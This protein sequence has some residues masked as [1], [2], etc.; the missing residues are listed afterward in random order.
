[1]SGS[2]YI[3]STLSASV[4][5]T[6]FDGS[7][8]PR[9]VGRVVI[10]GGANV[11]DKALVTPQGVMTKI[12]AEEYAQIKQDKVFQ[13]HVENGFIKV[14]SSSSDAEKVAKDMSEKDGSAQL[15]PTDFPEDGPQP[16]LVDED[17]KK[18]AKKTTT[19]KKTTAKKAK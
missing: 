17:D 16:V 19:P 11:I 15:Q 13:L 12:T 4:A 10:A 7:D 18:P 14:R 1:M 6:K 5:Y 8:V 9:P 2:Y 3:F